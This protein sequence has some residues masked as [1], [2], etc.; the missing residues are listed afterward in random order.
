MIGP[1]VT[2]P[3]PGAPCPPYPIAPGTPAAPP[4][5]ADNVSSLV[6]EVINLNI[7]YLRIFLPE[8]FM[9]ETLVIHCVS[10]T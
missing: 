4:V 7:S 1:S 3:F 9:V 8:L 5:P 6:V 2:S 10:I